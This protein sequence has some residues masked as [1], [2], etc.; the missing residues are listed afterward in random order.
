MKYFYYVSLCGYFQYNL[1]TW[2][3]SHVSARSLWHGSHLLLRWF[4]HLCL[5]YN[6]FSLLLF[7]RNKSLK[8]TFPP[9]WWKAAVKLTRHG[10]WAEERIPGADLWS[11]TT[12]FSG[13]AKMAKNEIWAKVS[14]KHKPNVFQLDQSIQQYCNIAGDI[15][16]RDVLSPC[17]LFKTPRTQWFD[18][19]L[20]ARYL[21]FEYSEATLTNPCFTKNDSA[22]TL[23]RLYFNVSYQYF[24][25]CPEKN[26]LLWILCSFWHIRASQPWWS[27]SALDEAF[28]HL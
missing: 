17:L 23:Y 2:T 22:G 11:S 13:S 20:I 21:Q 26:T 25:V 4:T 28:A 1:K 16:N 3:R 27:P 24:T 5:I 9:P 19:D 18:N 12:F 6:Y 7:Y 14:K 8:T 10:S 15:L